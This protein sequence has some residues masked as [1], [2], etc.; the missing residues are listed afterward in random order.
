[1][2]HAGVDQKRLKCNSFK[3]LFRAALVWDTLGAR[4][5]LVDSTA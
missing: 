2:V 1:M 4:A 5:T 3:T